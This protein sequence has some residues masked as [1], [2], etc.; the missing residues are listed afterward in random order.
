[1]KLI[2]KKY[3]KKISLFLVFIFLSN[4]SYNS[5][6]SIIKRTGKWIFFQ[7]ETVVLSY[8]SYNFLQ[9]NNKNQN[10]PI[11][12]RIKFLAI[13]SPGQTNQ[14]YYNIEIFSKNNHKIKTSIDTEKLK[15]NPCVTVKNLNT[16]QTNTACS[17]EFYINIDEPVNEEFEVYITS[18]ISKESNKN[19]TSK[20]LFYIHPAEF[21]IYPK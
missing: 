19:K 14:K 12:G 17:S 13:A 4:C 9:K 2:I 7:S 10:T 16:F 5:N 11:G 20:N 15:K 6:G 21:T 8:E 18:N 1:M 3:L